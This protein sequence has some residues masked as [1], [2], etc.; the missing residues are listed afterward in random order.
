[1]GSN[2]HD[3]LITWALSNQASL[4]MAILAFFLAFL[5]VVK[6]FYARDSLLVPISTRKYGLAMRALNWAVFG[7]VFLLFGQIIPLREL[8]TWRA[9][10]RIALLFL[11]LPEIAYQ[12]TILLPALK[13]K[14]WT[15][16]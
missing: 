7:G 10:A 4:F 1:M 11:M 9:T 5:Y 8:A 3:A 14:L 16:A 6:F 15:R 2:T 13:R 12:L